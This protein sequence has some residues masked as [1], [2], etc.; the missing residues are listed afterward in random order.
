MSRSKVLR[1]IDRF[2]KTVIPLYIVLRAFIPSRYE[3]IVV[4]SFLRVYKHIMSCF[5]WCPILSP[6]LHIFITRTT[7]PI[8]TLILMSTA[9]PPTQMTLLSMS[10]CSS[11]YRAPAWCSGGMGTIPVGTL[12]FFRCPMFVSC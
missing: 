7:R 11:V 1:I 2:E 6:P 10:S 4:K 12:R 3:L 5:Y 8:S 9:F